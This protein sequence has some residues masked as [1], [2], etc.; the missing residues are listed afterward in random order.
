M[1]RYMRLYEGYLLENPGFWWVEK[2]FFEV[3]ENEGYNFLDGRSICNIL[4]NDFEKYVR[5]FQ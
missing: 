3:G 2:I 1:F 4:N 5:I